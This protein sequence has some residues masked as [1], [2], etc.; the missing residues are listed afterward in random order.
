M[1]PLDRGRGP[2]ENRESRPADTGAALE[3]PHTDTGT[4]TTKARPPQ[5]EAGHCSPVMLMA[6][7]RSSRVANMRG[8]LR[9][10][11]S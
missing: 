9:V 4:N 2:P 3:K 5:H 11:A 6:G 8:G 1:R 7:P 10:E